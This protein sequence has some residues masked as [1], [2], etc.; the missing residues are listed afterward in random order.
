MALLFS[1]LVNSLEWYF[2]EK[3]LGRQHAAL[4]A[5]SNAAVGS[6]FSSVPAGV[7]TFGDIDLTDATHV[8]QTPTG[9]T[10]LVPGTLALQI[11]NPGAEKLS[12]NTPVD[13]FRK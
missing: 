12:E 11:P 4:K 3:G 2:A 13:G 7:T 10:G 1:D 6:G 9:I 5:F 8:D